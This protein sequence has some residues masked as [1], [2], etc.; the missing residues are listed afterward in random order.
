MV[1]LDQIDK[2]EILL[3]IRKHFSEITTEQFL[4]NLQRA[5]PFLWDA[6]LLTDDDFCRA[7]KSKS[8]DSKPFKP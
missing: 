6:S 5:A 8:E 1:E 3:E 4:E 7:V 2:Q